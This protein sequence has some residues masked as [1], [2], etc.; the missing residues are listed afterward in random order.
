VLTLHAAP[1]EPATTSGGRWDRLRRRERSRPDAGAGSS[2]RTRSGGRTPSG[3]GPPL[4]CPEPT[5]ATRAATAA[6]PRAFSLQ[7]Q[8]LRE[9]PP[10]DLLGADHLQRPVSR[11]LPEQPPEHRRL[12]GTR[13]APPVHRTG[14][15]DERRRMT[16]RD[17]RV[18]RDGGHERR[19]RT[20]SGSRR[21]GASRRMP[22]S[23][24]SPRLSAL[25]TIVPALP[26]RGRCR[27]RRGTDPDSPSAARASSASVTEMSVRRPN[28]RAARHAL[29]AHAA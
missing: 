6:R 25:S 3:C 1:A 19:V 15:R 9:V 26:V 18:V 7:H 12:I 28:P 23:R 14:A 4:P 13:R 29:D 20:C 5:S 11:V 27:P 10:L 22:D 21:I 16:V 2:G 24:W 8:G 17:E